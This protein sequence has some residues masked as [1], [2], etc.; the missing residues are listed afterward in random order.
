M[1]TP[2]LEEARVLECPTCQFKYLHHGRIVTHTRREDT[3]ADVQ[4]VN[5][6]V[7]ERRYCRAAVRTL[8][9]VSDLVLIGSAIKCIA[10]GAFKVGG[11]HG[12]KATRYWYRKTRD[13]KAGTHLHH[14][15]IRRSGW[16]KCIPDAIKNQPW[17]LMRMSPAKHIRVHGWGQHGF[18]VFGKLWHGTPRWAKAGAYAV[19]HRAAYSCGKMRLR[20][21]KLRRR[22]NFS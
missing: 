9:V 10:K 16:G 21:H 20:T 2:R 7:H 1:Q 19:W 11:S 13:L 8:L 15:L 5:V 12:W 4:V 6:P 18:R 14:W 22:D 17:N 3:D